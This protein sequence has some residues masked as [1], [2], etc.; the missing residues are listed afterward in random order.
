[1][2]QGPLEV[3][4]MGRKRGAAGRSLITAV[5]ANVSNKTKVKDT[6]VTQ[7]YPFPFLAI[8][9]YWQDGAIDDVRS[10]LGLR[11]LLE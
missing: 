11:P 2:S 6:S 5:I 3:S 10:V 1:M 8:I 7:N 4:Y 9:C